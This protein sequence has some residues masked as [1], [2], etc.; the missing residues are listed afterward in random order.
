MSDYL[1]DDIFNQYKNP[2][3]INPEVTKQMG[4]VRQ[5]SNRLDGYVQDAQNMAPKDDT[6]KAAAL[7][8]DNSLYQAIG[9]RA[10]SQYN[11]NLSQVMNEMKRAEPLQQLN[12]MQQ[13]QGIT[14][15]RY[16][17]YLAEWQQVQQKNA[18]KK[19]ARG[20]VLGTI[21]GIGAA[22]V[23]GVYGGPGGA[24]AGYQAGSGVGNWLGGS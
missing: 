20:G 10:K 12:M 21:L 3:F 19:A 17:A 1:N 9:N 13:Q 4:E 2:R 24:A 18:A 14:G 16:N 23:G 8:G 11:K 6:F 7:G 22:V 5:F 15:A